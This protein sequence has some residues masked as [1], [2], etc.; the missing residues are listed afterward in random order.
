MNNLSPG[1]LV[2]SLDLELYWGM[3]DV[4]SLS[5]YQENLIGVR[6]AISAMLQLFTKYEVHATWATLGFLYYD[7]FEQLK[8]NLP[9]KL[10][11]YS[12]DR[13]SPYEYINHPIPPEE[14]ELHFCPDAIES[15]AQCSGQEI[16][17]HTFSHYYCLEEGQ[18][19]AEFKA[20]LQAAIAVAQQANIN[21]KS[22]VFPRNQYNEA[23]LQ[24]IAECGID[25]YRGNQKNA[26][27]NEENGDGDRPRKRILR[28]LDA[29]FNLTGYNTYSRSHSGGGSSQL[30]SSYPIN[31]PA[32][33]FLRPYS[34]K[35]KYL[36]RL[37]LRRI[38][39]SLKHAA[40]RGEIYHL[41]WHP[42]NFGIN[43]AEN[44]NF[45]EQ[46]LQ[47]YQNLNR[48]NKMQ[49]LNMGEVADLYT[50]YE[51]QMSVV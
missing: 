4:V 45:L 42:H 50:S 26:I 43:L 5:D 16:A 38:T 35:L 49:S 31:I 18:T 44:L 30:Q 11:S 25:C 2:I 7:S 8:D 9:P 19:Q 22:L 10:P 33:H 1:T 32:S 6:R 29:Y 17:T 37:R 39:S 34:P 21:T 13:L 36:D 48:Q 46:I 40:N 12:K 23:Y 41:W 28:L 3:R 15:I 14:L 47:S 27:Y 20:D 51:K 24:A